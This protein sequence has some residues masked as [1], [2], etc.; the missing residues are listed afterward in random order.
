MNRYGLI[1][2][3]ILDDH[4]FIR[5]GVRE[6]LASEARIEV[7]GEAATAELAVAMVP[8]LG[9]DVA[10]LDVRL[11]RGSGV[12]ACR[13][14][15]SACPQTACLMLTG[16]TNE[17][18]MLAS[19]MAG[20]AGYVTKLGVGEE[21]AEAVH[22]VAAGQTLLSKEGIWQVREQLNSLAAASTSELSTQDQ[23]VLM[24]I[25]EGLT[26]SE[27]AAQLSLPEQSVRDSV[28]SL[29]ATIDV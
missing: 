19:V 27:I 12:A 8:R 2:V 21:L 3:F 25:E 15:R 5:L 11:P 29:L 26:N 20:S 18:A 13:D 16:H 10:L 6:R 4:E 28:S 24:L 17:K 22:A 1:R 7:V 9:V 23:Q 14:I